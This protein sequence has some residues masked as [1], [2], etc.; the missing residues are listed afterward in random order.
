MYHEIQRGWETRRVEIY[1]DGPMK[2]AGDELGP[3][4]PEL[5]EV[6]FPPIEEIAQ[7]PETI[8]RLIEA[9]EFEQRWA[10]AKRRACGY[11][12]S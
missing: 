9:A 1:R 8:P 10:E 12:R 6:E 5:A 3:E 7:E 4:D 11:P 2:V